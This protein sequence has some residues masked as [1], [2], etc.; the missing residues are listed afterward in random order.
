MLAHHICLITDKVTN[1][2]ADP[3]S[4]PIAFKGD[5]QTGANG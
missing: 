3:L 4:G 5:F 2:E 1:K